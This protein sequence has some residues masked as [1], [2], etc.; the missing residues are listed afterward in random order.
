[1]KEPILMT[2]RHEDG[3]EV[4]Q[5]GL[6]KI[7]VMFLWP[8]IWYAILIYGIAGP[9]VPIGE[10]VSSWV[11]LLIVAV[12]PGSEFLVG[13]ILLRREGYS[14]GDGAWQQRIRWRWCRGSASR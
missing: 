13:V 6:W 3:I 9:L 2:S 12:G 10:K 5:D 11:V 8:A 4:P 1:M 7:L 14:I